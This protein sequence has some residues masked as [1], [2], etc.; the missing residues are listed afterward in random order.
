M[1]KLTKNRKLRLPSLP[2]SVLLL[3][4]L[5]GFAFVGQAEAS[6]EQVVTAPRLLTTDVQDLRVEFEDTA[7][8]AAWRT[9]ITVASKL[10][11]RLN[12]QHR[13]YRL[14]SQSGELWRNA[15]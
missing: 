8:D 12:V 6:D 7:K 5:V 2:Y 10:C 15:G 13:P 14:A 1:E 9:R 4:T 3:T 11:A